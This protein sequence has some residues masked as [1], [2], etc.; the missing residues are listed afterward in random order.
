MN[1]IL[2]AFLEPVLHAL[3]NTLDSNLTNRLFKNAWALTVFIAVAD[4]LFLP[5][6]WLFNK[7]QLISLSLVP[8]VLIIAFIELFY[9]YPYYKALQNSDTSI[10]I[11]LFSLGHVLV[12]ILAFFF[13]GE[14]LLPIQYLGFLIIV[15]S[16][17]ALTYNPKEKLKLNKSFFYMLFSSSLLAIEVVIYKHVFNQVSWGTGFFWTIAVSAMIGLLSY[18]IPKV[19]VNIQSELPHLRRYYLIILLVGLVGFIGNI[20][21]SYTVSQVSPTVSRSISSFQP[22]FVLV[23]AIIFKKYFPLAFKE[24][25][26]LR[27]MVQ[28]IILFIA[29]A[30][31]VILTI[32]S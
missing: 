21:F 3:A 5:A 24:E 19:G 25:V 4:I 15:F 17:A 20:G 27:N 14:K 13:V 23:Y 18:A 2:I 6:I 22:I 30:V 31:G 28:K 7:P 11:S 8:Y 16:S 10:A 29:I 32:K 9:S 12:P 1:W 26:N